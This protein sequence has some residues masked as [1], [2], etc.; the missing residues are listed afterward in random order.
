MTDLFVIQFR[1][2]QPDMS[3]ETRWVT[4]THP[5]DGHAVAQ[6]MA[7]IVR[8]HKQGMVEIEDYRIS[9]VDNCGHDCKWCND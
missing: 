4:T 7:W 3:G 5:M 1:D 8:R 9:L 2:E 6:A